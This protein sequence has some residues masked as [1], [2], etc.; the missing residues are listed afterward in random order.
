MGIF[1]GIIK[2]YN[3]RIN[4]KVSEAVKRNPENYK[5]YRASSPDTKEKIRKKK[6]EEVIR[7]DLKKARYILALTGVTVVL[8]AGMSHSIDNN[9]KDANEPI[10]I[11]TETT[12]QRN[13]LEIDIENSMEKIDKIQSKQDTINF[14]TEVYLDE[15][16][17]ENN[18]NIQPEDIKFYSKNQDMIYEINLGDNERISLTH[19]SWPEGVELKLENDNINYE[20]KEDPKI[21]GVKE[22]QED[23]S[24]KY[25][26]NITISDDGEVLNVIFGDDYIDGELL[27][28]KDGVVLNN[29]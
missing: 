25:I 18:T 26:E 14:F 6:A 22:K 20:I 21:Y 23:G 5:Q 7:N 17:K 29:M 4:N 8:G 28:K 2:K 24:Y 15:Y 10:S 1:N 9:K 13:Q 19:G 11:E 27:E 16:N 12:L 3:N